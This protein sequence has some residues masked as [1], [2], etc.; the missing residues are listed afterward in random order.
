M[1]IDKTIYAGERV[2]Q[3]T[4]D[5]MLGSVKEDR[6]IGEAEVSSEVYQ[7]TTKQR[8]KGL[9]D[10]PYTPIAQYSLLSVCCIDVGSAS[11][12]VQCAAQFSDQTVLLIVW[13]VVSFS[14]QWTVHF[15]S[16]CSTVYS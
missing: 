7:K 1:L 8:F 2:T 10:F 6:R 4:L 9:L 11:S 3:F 15:S 13:C 12:I 5:T 14:V 16:V